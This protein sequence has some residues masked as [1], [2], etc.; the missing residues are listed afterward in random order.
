MDAG[1]PTNTTKLVGRPLNSC[2]KI[3]YSKDGALGAQ[4][5]IESE[6]SKI[7]RGNM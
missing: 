3:S 2:F 7:P 6:H 4:N 1:E 5:A